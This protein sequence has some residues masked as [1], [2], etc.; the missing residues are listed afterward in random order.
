[1]C[2][3]GTYL[4]QSHCIC[5]YALVNLILPGTESSETSSNANNEMTQSGMSDSMA[6]IPHV[7]STELAST[8]DTLT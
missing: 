7:S 3:V 8:T 1:M 2:G 4:I 5:I 6:T